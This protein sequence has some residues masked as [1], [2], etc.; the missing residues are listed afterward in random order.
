MERV[1]ALTE[2]ETELLKQVRELA[3][4]DPE[5]KKLVDRISEGLI[6]KYWLDDGLVYASGGRLYIPT[7]RLRRKLM[8]ESHNTQWAGHPERD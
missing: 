8:E 5:Y 3:Q 6:R 7:G 1:T 2:V 4:G